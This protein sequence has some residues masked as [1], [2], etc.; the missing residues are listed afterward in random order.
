MKNLFFL[1]CIFSVSIL[2]A[3]T[4]NKE[5]FD[6]ANLNYK[7][8][9]YQK[10]I[11]VYQEIEANDA[12]SSALFFNLGNSYYKVNN[13][14]NTIYYY[15]KALLLDPLNSDAANN[16]EFAKRMTIDTIEEL[17]KSFLQKIEFNYIQKFSYN[18]W[19]VFS[20][21]FAMLFT[22]LF[23][24]FYFSR[25]SSKRR[26]YFLTSLLSLVFFIFSITISYQQ[27]GQA[28]TKK[29]GIILVSKVI[30]KNAPTLNSDEIFTLH[31]GTKIAILDAVDD[32]KKIAL[33]DGKIG[34]TLSENLKEL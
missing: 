29:Y 18:Q 7:E 28:K 17:P 6:K 11:N 31:E 1:L 4:S 22:A 24:L 8:G 27:Y 2:A 23:L 13:V 33:P 15:E 14:A 20:V 25:I 12:I 3:Q 19:A 16:L 26:L 5:L 32:W 30:V 10:A 9:K 21:G 34:W